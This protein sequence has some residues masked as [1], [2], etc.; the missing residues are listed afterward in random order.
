MKKGTIIL[1][2]ALLLGY[3]LYKNHSVK[4]KEIS[5]QLIESLDV[6]E[7]LY[8]D[9]YANNKSYFVPVGSVINEYSTY[10]EIIIAG[11][12]EKIILNKV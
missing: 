12:Q 6:T 9:D 2:L 8:A 10:Y 7:S 1:A 4:K 11:T 5:E 3:V